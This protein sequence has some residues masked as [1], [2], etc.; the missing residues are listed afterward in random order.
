MISTSA[1]SFKATSMKLILFSFAFILLSVV[2]GFPQE[3]KRLSHGNYHSF[4]LA[5]STSTGKFS[6][7][8]SW[9][10]LHGAALK[11][12]LKV[13]YGLRFTS[14]V[15]ANKYYTTAPSKYTSPI[16]NLG[17][18]FSENIEENIDT[19]TVATA[20]TNSV[21]L[22]FYIE[23]AISSRLYLGFNIDVVGF[24]FGPKKQFNIISSSFDQGQDPVQTGS[25]TRFNLLLTSDNDIGSL[26]SEF[27]FKYQISK[28]IGLRIGY[29]FLFSE[30]Q[31]DKNLSFNNSQILNDRYRNKASM[32]LLAVNLKPF[33]N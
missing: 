13:G 26:N 31:T 3:K 9:S 24:S 8:L 19:I 14:F 5:L 32:I 2:S 29:T 12:K 7:A 22:A 16:Q 4:D 18:I 11:Q 17:T 10:Y 23:Y 25:P 28:K 27:Y 33:H 21:N 15:A 30:Y 20:S 1:I 6:A